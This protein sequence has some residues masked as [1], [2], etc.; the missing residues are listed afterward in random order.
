LISIFLVKTAGLSGFLAFCMKD[1]LGNTTRPRYYVADTCSIAKV[2]GNLTIPSR[3]PV[4]FGRLHERQLRRV[5]WLCKT[6]F[7]RKTCWNFITT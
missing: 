1:D 2:S 5:E 3:T 6:E 4:D 7:R